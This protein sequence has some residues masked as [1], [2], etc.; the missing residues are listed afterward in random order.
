[1]S[2]FMFTFK[3][4]EKKSYKDKTLNLLI[5]PPKDKQF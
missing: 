2:Y 3:H 5:L 1:M 4:L